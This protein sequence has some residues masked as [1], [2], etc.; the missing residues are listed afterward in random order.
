MVKV[1]TS[2]KCTDNWKENVNE[3]TAL[4]AQNKGESHPL[5]SLNKDMYGWLFYEQADMKA[6][7]EHGHTGRVA[8]WNLKSKALKSYNIHL[9]RCRTNTQTI[10]IK[11]MN[12]YNQCTK[13]IKLKN[14]KKKTAT[15]S[16]L[17]GPK[18]Q[19]F[20]RRNSMPIQAQ[21]MIHDSALQYLPLK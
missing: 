21:F 14:I 19:I 3:A 2:D 1:A 13:I 5:G 17:L 15:L 6:F 9:S 10:I 12:F 20:I 18:I 11:S 8:K 4:L 16:V 7:N